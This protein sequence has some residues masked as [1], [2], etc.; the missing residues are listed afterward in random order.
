MVTSTI[1]MQNLVK[2]KAEGS[3]CIQKVMTKDFRNMSSDMPLSELG[4]VLERQ[5][6]VFVDGMYI[7]SSFDM[8]RFM[9]ET[10]EE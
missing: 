2:K 7:A 6:F 8:L 3:D 5:N 1:L 10:M 9:Q 4:R